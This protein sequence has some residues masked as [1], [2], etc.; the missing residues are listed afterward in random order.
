MADRPVLIEM[1]REFYGEGGYPLDQEW[2]MASFSAFLSN[3]AYGSIWIVSSEHKPAG[4]GVL[5]VRFSM[6]YGGLDAFIDDLFVRP[7]YRQHGLGQALMEALLDECRRRQILALHVEVG[8]DN[9]PAIALYNKSRLG[10]RTDNRQLLTRNL[11]TTSLE[12][13]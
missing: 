13:E 10:P 2:A 1:M 6:E 5:T 9:A 12:V 8:Q 4:Y 11:E 7:A 3:E